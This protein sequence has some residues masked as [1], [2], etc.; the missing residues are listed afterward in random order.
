VSSAC[1]AHPVEDMT[2]ET[3]TGGKMRVVE[4][5]AGS[6]CIPSFCIT[7]REGKIG[8]SSERHDLIEAEYPEPIVKYS[9]RSF[10]SYTLVPVAV[11][12]TPPDLVGRSERRVERGRVKPDEAGERAGGVDLDS[13]EGPSALGEPGGD[14]I[15]EGVALRSGEDGGKVLH[16]RRVGVERRER[17]PVF[18]SPTPQAQPDSAQFD[19]VEIHRASLPSKQLIGRTY[20]TGFPSHATIQPPGRRLRSAGRSTSGTLAGQQAL[21]PI[22]SITKVSDGPL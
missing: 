22:V 12:E 5:V 9:L 21:T 15:D 10:S 2:T 18:L 20:L 19:D 14:A 8:R 17:L 11:G 3:V 7:R 1:A 4:V 13:P 16:D 6:W